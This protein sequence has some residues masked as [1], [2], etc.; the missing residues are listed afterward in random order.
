MVPRDM[1]RYLQSARLLASIDVTLPVSIEPKKNI[2]RLAGEEYV[3]E[4]RL[5][6]NLNKPASATFS[7]FLS[8][9]SWVRGRLDYNDY[10]DA[11]CVKHKHIYTRED[12]QTTAMIGSS[13][14]NEGKG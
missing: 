5:S 8:H 14:G 9:H 1:P 7:Y 10:N 11:W 6:S 13:A 2:N 3:T 12:F 4:A